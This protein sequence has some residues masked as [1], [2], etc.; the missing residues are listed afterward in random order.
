MCIKY[1]A[2][3]FIRT[4]PTYNNRNPWVVSNSCQCVNNI[5]LAKIVSFPRHP[6]PQGH[7]LTHTP[8]LIGTM[9]HWYPV[10]KAIDWMMERGLK[11][12]WCIRNPFQ[13]RNYMKLAQEIEFIMMMINPFESSPLLQFFFWTHVIYEHLLNSLVSFIYYYCLVALAIWTVSVTDLQ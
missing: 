7:Y 10:H 5:F 13:P 9:H 11:K 3:C 6:T 1:T 12:K 8:H 4:N 2:P